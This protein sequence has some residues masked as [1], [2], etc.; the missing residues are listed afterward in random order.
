MPV[1]TRNSA[2]SNALRGLGRWI[3]AFTLLFFSLGIAKAAYPELP[4]F[5]QVSENLYR[6][7]QPREKGLELLAQLGIQTIINLRGSGTQ[8]RADEEEAKALG[9]T[10]YHVPLPVWGRPRNTSIET[11]LEIIS[12]SESGRVFIHCKDGVDRTGT[13]VALF[14]VTRESWPTEKAI[15]EARQQ[16]MRRYQVWMR[17]YIEDYDAPHSSSSVAEKDFEDRVGVGVRVG[18]RAILSF[19]KRAKRAARHAHQSVYDAFD[20]VF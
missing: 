18:E 20:R 5:Q 12:K 15:A 6:G 8:T 1:L 17:D 3:T 10:Y 4:R 14:R 11:I 16:G 9:L 7:A 2:R 19:R 13:I